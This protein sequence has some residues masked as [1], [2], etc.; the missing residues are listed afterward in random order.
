MGNF[1]KFSRGRGN[2]F[3]GRDFD[4]G[5]GPRRRLGSREWDRSQMHEATCSD[6]GKSCEVPFVPTGEKPVYCNQCF[7]IHR[8]SSS[9]SPA[10]RDFS[11]PGFGERK[12]FGLGVDNAP[13]QYKEQFDALN[14]KLDKI[15]SV[16]IPSGPAKAEAVVKEQEVKIKKGKTAK[17]DK[18]K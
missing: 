15:L 13:N 6:C 12:T 8:G 4:R 11:R 16:L 1:N 7:S 3:G 5:G 9:A 17:A 2:G 10:R 18:K 14:N